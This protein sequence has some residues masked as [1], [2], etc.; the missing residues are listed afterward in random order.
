M[1]YTRVFICFSRDDTDYFKPF[2]GNNLCMVW[3]SCYYS[4]TSI[5]VGDVLALMVSS[6]W[7]IS[8]P[9]D[10]L[11]ILFCFMQVYVSAY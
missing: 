9:F 2:L 11:A 8:V 10:R 5:V 3:W 7:P 6:I 4:L 1:P